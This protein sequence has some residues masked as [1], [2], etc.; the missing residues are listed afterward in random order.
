[1]G[2]KDWFKSFSKKTKTQTLQPVTRGGTIDDDMAATLKL[3]ETENVKQPQEA[4]AKVEVLEIVLS[5]G[6]RLG[7]VVRN[8]GRC[9]IRLLGSPLATQQFICVTAEQL[10]MLKEKG[11]EI[12]NVAVYT[13][14]NNK[15]IVRKLS[16]VVI[17]ERES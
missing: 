9:S 12:T 6:Q 14:T 4:G 7:Y 3:Q 15:V 2:L 10:L 11:V 17:P 16:N 13:N 1:M 5:K 8:I